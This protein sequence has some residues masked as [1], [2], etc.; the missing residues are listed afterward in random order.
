MAFNYP[1]VWRRQGPWSGGSS[2]AMPRPRLP[3]AYSA[4]QIVG[5]GCKPKAGSSSGPLPCHFLDRF[6]L[7][8]ILDRMNEMSLSNARCLVR[9]TLVASSLLSEA[10]RSLNEVNR[11]TVFM[12]NK[13]GQATTILRQL[14]GREA[15]D[16]PHGRGGGPPL[17]GAGPQGADGVKRAVRGHSASS[18][19]CHSLLNAVPRFWRNGGQRFAALRRR[20]FSALNFIRCT[21]LEFS[22][23][24][25]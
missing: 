10:L 1:V 9:I 23:S 5:G 3:P 22:T 17:R 15:K 13:G 20:G 21:K 19:R 24:H 25:S 4:R 8:T 2:H 7:R 6:F 11:L 16:L 14:A 18:R 12:A